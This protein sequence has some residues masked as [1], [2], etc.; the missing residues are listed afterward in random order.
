[1]TIDARITQAITEAVKEAG[2]PDTLAR[3]LIAWFEAVTSGNEDINDQ[4]T[5]VRH[6]EVLFE[7]TVVENADGE[8]A[9]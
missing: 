6:L 3:R 9:D 5:A 8:D 1:M 7:G 4:A 2:Q